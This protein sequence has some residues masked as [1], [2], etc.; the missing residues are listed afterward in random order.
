MYWMSNRSDQFFCGII[1][2]DPQ[3]R[4]HFLFRHFVQ[5]C[6]P[7]FPDGNPSFFG[8]RGILNSI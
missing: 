6:S 5:K 1:I 8:Y 4:D 7:A 3:G 2:E